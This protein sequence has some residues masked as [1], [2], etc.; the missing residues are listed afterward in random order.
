MPKSVFE[1]WRELPVCNT[2]GC[3]SDFKKTRCLN[4]LSHYIA[5]SISPG[6]GKHD[7]WYIYKM[8][9]NVH[10]TYQCGYTGWRKRGG[11]I[12][13]RGVHQ[14]PADFS[15][16]TN[17]PSL[18]GEDPEYR[19]LI[20][21]A[22]CGSVIT[23][24]S[25][26]QWKLIMH[27]SAPGNEVGQDIRILDKEIWMDFIMELDVYSIYRIYQYNYT[28]VCTSVP[29]KWTGIIKMQHNVREPIYKSKMGTTC[30]PL[31]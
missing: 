31:R 11:P 5:L 21:T 25:C 7:T 24:P 19:S 1:W 14:T 30:T 2:V 27:A 10:C 16:Q 23:R 22:A 17:S 20:C 8:Y 26:T 4:Y 28:R 9:I 12:T 13:K 6:S 15:I 18:L 29:P 3:H